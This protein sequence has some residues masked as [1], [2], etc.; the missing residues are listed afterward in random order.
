MQIFTDGAF[1]PDAEVV[2]SMREAMFDAA[3]GHSEFFG[4][5]IASKLVKQWRLDGAENV[6][7]HAELLSVVPSRHLCS[8]TIQDRRRSFMITIKVYK[9]R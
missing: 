9:Q 8:S 7:A 4:E 3:S 5:E 1:E 6:I 2:A